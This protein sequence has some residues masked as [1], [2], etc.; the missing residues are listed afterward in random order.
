MILGKMQFIQLNKEDVNHIEIAKSLWVPFVVDQ[1]RL[2]GE[3]FDIGQITDNL[4]RRIGIQ[5]LR[6]T[7]HFELCYIDNA[8]VGIS[9]FAIDLGGIKGLVD[10]GYGYIMG[11]YIIPE[12]RRLGY[13]KMFYQHIEKVFIEHGAKSIYLTTNSDLGISFWKSL[14]FENSTKLD[15]D[16]HMPIYIKDI[17]S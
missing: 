16:E 4:M 1:K 6:D 2:R 7:M 11:F 3:V 12:R 14:G 5:G 9:N 13:G 15:P 8:C 10:P 17:Q